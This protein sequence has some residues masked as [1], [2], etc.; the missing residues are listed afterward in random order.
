MTTREPFYEH[1]P[2]EDIEPEEA[3]WRRECAEKSMT[4]IIAALLHIKRATSM[5]VGWYAV[6]Y[7]LDLIPEPMS[8]V[9]AALRVERGTISASARQFVT[10]NGLPL[11]NIMRSEEASENYKAT[12]EKQLCKTNKR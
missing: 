5:E 7:A 11:S 6:A 10:E 12:R 9:A 1:H 8:K 3:H 4:V 2:V